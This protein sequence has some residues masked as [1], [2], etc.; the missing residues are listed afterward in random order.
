MKT[1]TL[2]TES[3]NTH[4]DNVNISR[5]VNFM[6]TKLI[7]EIQTKAW[8]AALEAAA[9]NAEAT[10]ETLDNHHSY[11]FVDNQSILKLKK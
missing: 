6:V 11:P 2:L 7:A 3:I 5:E 10:F 1:L 9:E 4:I 8:N